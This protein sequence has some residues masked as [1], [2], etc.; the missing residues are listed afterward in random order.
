MSGIITDVVKIV[1]RRSRITGRRIIIAVRIFGSARPC[2][3]FLFIGRRV[4]FAERCLL[5]N[6]FRIVSSRRNVL[7]FVRK[8]IF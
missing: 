5:R 8:L 4:F 3:R 2:N 1:F 7:V 6:G